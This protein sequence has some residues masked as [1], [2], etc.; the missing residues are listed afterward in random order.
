MAKRAQ[1]AE[2]SVP[3]GRIDARD[4]GDEKIGLGQVELAAEDERRDRARRVGVAHAGRHHAEALVRAGDLRIGF[5]EAGQG[6]LLRQRLAVE[7]RLRLAAEHGDDDNLRRDRRA[8][9]AGRPRQGCERQG[10]E[11]ER[12]RDHG[13]L[14]WGC[15]AATTR[16]AGAERDRQRH[17]VWLNRRKLTPPVR[18]PNRDSPSS[19]RADSWAGTGGRSGAGRARS[20][21]RALW[22]ATCARRM[23]ACRPS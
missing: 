21:D 2:P 15:S 4:A 3:C 14:P 5:G 19:S 9:R 12:A 20:A 23:A 13:G 8:V 7:P 16:G 6:E 1:C 10:G 22:R 17:R 11:D 18:C